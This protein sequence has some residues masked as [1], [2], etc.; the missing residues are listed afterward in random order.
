M[1]L[2]REHHRLYGYSDTSRKTEIVNVRLMARG[3][4]EA[5]KFARDE[6]VDEAPDAALLGNQQVVFDSE[7]HP[8]PVYERAKLRAGNRLI[9]PAIISE[10][11]ATT[12]IEPNFNA[13]VDRFRNLLLTRQ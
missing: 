12:V 5:P 8:T 6:E 3:Q 9:G 4:V 11:N 7:T 13:K 10:A 1:D 2:N